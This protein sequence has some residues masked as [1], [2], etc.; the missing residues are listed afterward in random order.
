MCP[1]AVFKLRPIGREILRGV[2]SPSASLKAEIEISIHRCFPAR[3]RFW[4]RGM[5]VK[6][7]MVESLRVNISRR[8]NISRVVSGKRRIK[9]LKSPL[10]ISE[11]KIY[12]GNVL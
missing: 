3:E 4:R 5:R 1:E 11:V 10:K 6:L 7:G 2:L 8:E 9:P 12:V